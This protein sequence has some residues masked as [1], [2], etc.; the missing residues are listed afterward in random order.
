MIDGH[1]DMKNRWHDRTMILDLVCAVVVIQVALL[2]V[3]WRG[4]AWL[5]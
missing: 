2:G 4:V 3:A 5:A 1:A